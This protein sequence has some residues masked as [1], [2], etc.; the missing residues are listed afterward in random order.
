[1]YALLIGMLPV[2]APGNSGAQEYTGFP[3]KTVTVQD[4]FQT[5]VG[6]TETV[7]KYSLDGD[8]GS[9]RTFA[10]L[11][12]GY[13]KPIGSAISSSY[14]ILDTVNGAS[15]VKK[16]KRYLLSNGCEPLLS[17][18]NSNESKGGLRLNLNDVAG[19]VESV[20]P[21]GKYW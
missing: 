2:V 11:N 9:R 20:S 3:V 18:I 14:L 16:T 1:M 19:V 13:L 17:E 15:Q 6:P 8:F 12:C 5:Q 4:A 10:F 7:A 21:V